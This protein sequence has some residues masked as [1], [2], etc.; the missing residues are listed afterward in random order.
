MTEELLKLG[1]EAAQTGDFEKA[2]S[3]FAKVVQANPNSEL[4]WLYLGHCLKDQNKKR[5][6]YERVLKINPSNLQAIEALAKVTG[7]NNA[8]PDLPA[9]LPSIPETRQ[10][11]PLST[12]KK[13]S[14]TSTPIIFGAA[15]AFIVCLG[16]L[17]GIALLSGVLT[18]EA[19]GIPINQV[20]LNHATSTAS[21]TIVPT[22]TVT[23][24]PTETP[25]PSPTWVSTAEPL[26]FSIEDLSSSDLYLNYDVAYWSQII[27][28]DPK[29]ADAYYQRASSIYK[30]N[31]GI[32]SLE[33]Y[34]WKLDLVLQDMDVAIALRSDVGDYYTLRS[35]IYS[36]LINSVVYEV[37]REYLIGLALD[38]ADKADQLGTSIDE[39][40]DRTV[41]VD[42]IYTNQCDKAL[43]EVQQLIAEIQPDNPNLG[44]LLRIRAE[45]YACLGKL[46]DALK[47]INDSMFNN[48]NM[49]LKNQLKFMYLILLGRYKE[50]LPLLDNAI[51]D[52]KL[53]GWQYYWRAEIYYNTGKK[54][55]VQGELSAGMPKTWERGGMLPYVEA[56]LALDDGR[57]EDAIQLLQ[58][59]EATLDPTLNALRW[60]IQ[61]QLVRLDAKPLELTPSVP[62]LG[63]PIP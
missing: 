12:N 16:M 45:A 18:G 41:I 34:T 37:D 23:R 53:V 36:D 6:C 32:G 26:S 4:G 57:K 20:F 2:G 33:V 46:D 38:N 42:L 13:A 43:H 63:T 39:F 25:Y 22:S 15:L 44:G 7:L 47:S 40:S 31:Q 49:Q 56:Q 29:N 5:F 24:V 55:L 59:A 51:C 58:T 27:K 1:V 10:Q 8:A 9:Q 62:Y 54:N 52:C 21:P 60:K 61:K 14:R 17:F 3:Y 50:A 11:N 28:Q 48:E 19:S 30:L 35:Q